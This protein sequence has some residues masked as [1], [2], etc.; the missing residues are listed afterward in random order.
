MNLNYSEPEI[1]TNYI[2]FMIFR[3]MGFIQ[4][5]HKPKWISDR[6]R[7]IQNPKMNLYQTVQT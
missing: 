1:N 3:I 5:E 2:F 7:N 4:T 6:I